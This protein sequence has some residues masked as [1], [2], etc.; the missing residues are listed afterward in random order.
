MRK[1]K[2]VFIREATTWKPKGEV[3]SQ[4]TLMK[5][6][7]FTGSKRKLQISK[8]PLKNELQL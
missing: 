3:F 6:E 5:C 4:N 2:I 1:K 7:R 8:N